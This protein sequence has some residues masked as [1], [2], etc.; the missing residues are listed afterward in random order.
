MPVRQLLQRESF[1]IQALITRL[2]RPTKVLLPWTGWS[3]SRREVS[4]SHLQLQ[5]VTGLYRISASLKR[6][7]RSIVS[8][9]SILLDTLTSLSR[10][11]VHFVYLTELLVYLMQRVVLS[12]SQRTFGVRLIHTT[13]HVW[14][15]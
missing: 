5:L 1:I 3:R 12:L 2:V 11:S 10:L 7:L 6:V 9:S 15:L 4:Q 8:T 14:H 13:Y